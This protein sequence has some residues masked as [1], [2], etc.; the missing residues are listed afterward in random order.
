[1]AGAHAV[2][3]AGCG[4]QAVHIDCDGRMSRLSVQKRPRAR[5]AVMRIQLLPEDF[6]VAAKMTQQNWSLPLPVLPTFASNN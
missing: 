6:V 4:L 1:M 3:T 5:N 2:E